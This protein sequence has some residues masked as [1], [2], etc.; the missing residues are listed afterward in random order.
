MNI[1]AYTYGTLEKKNGKW[2]FKP[3]DQDPDKVG[4]LKYSLEKGDPEVLESIFGEYKKDKIGVLNPNL[5][6]LLKRHGYNVELLKV[7]SY[8]P[9][10]ILLETGFVSSIENAI[11]YISQIMSS[12]TTEKLKDEMTNKDLLIIHAINAYDEYTEMIN[13]LYERLREWYGVYFPELKEYIKKLDRY[14]LLVRDLLSRE[15]F[16]KEVLIER[17]YPIERA[18]KISL[19]ASNSTGGML[20]REDLEIIRKHADQLVTLIK[21]REEIDKYLKDLLEEEAPNLSRLIGHKLAARL[22]AKAGGIRKLATLPSS[23]VQLLGAEKSLFIAL[24][25]GGKPPKHG[26]IFQHPFINQSPRVVRGRIA[27]LLAGKI[28]IAARVDAF[29]GEFIGDKLYNEVL[30]RVNQLRKEA[31]KIKEKKMAEKRLYIRKKRRKRRR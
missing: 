31:P 5:Y 9:L 12:Y 11:E 18:E 17:G 24:R 13:I 30:E 25:K 29:G 22:I 10:K 20:S 14:A 4:R 28:S 23:T 16:S 3:F 1:I 15:N 8:N 2:V 26:I 7:D 6:N 19:A 21:Q 27:R